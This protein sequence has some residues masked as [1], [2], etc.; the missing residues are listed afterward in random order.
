M[1]HGEVIFID[2]FGNLITNVPAE[3][4]SLGIDSVQIG[5]Q[6]ITRFVKTYGLA[7]SGELIALISSN[8]YLEI[9]EVNG[10]AAKRLNIS[11]GQPVVAVAYKPPPPRDTTSSQL[12]Y[13]T[14]ARITN[15]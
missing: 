4:I 14:S 7:Q 15:K 2:H 11:R 1:L 10:N 3:A 8:G 12:P 5:N 6:T 13:N 9:A